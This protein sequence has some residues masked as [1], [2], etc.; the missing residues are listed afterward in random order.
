M[1]KISRISFRPNRSAR[2]CPSPALAAKKTC[3]QVRKDLNVYS[4]TDIKRP[5][6]RKDLNL[7]SASGTPFIIKVLTDLDNRLHTFFYRH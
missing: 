6:G 7:F 3:F 5:K 2:A 1:S 4:I